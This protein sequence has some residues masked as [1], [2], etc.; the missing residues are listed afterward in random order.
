MS[1]LRGRLT[2][3]LLVGTGLLLAA[4]GLALDLVIHARLLRD[5]D[6]HLAV[7]ARSLIALV[8]QQEGRIWLELADTMMPEFEAAKEADYFQI[9]SGDGSPV[10]R[11][12]SLGARHLP[13]AG[14]P[15][16]RPLIRDL[17]LPDGR[18]GRLVE[19]RFHPRYEDDE[20]YA[21]RGGLPAPPTGGLEATIVVASSREELDAFLSSLHRILALA[22]LALLAGTTLLV[23][24]SL[25]VGL[26][27][28]DD[29]GHRLTAM[30]ADSL[31]QGLDAKGAPAELLPLLLRFEELL[32]RLQAS[33]QRE[34]EFSAHLAHELRTPL[35]ELRA[36]A[37]VAL[38]WPD[39]SAQPALFEEVRD[40]GLQME[41]IVLNLLALAR[42]DGGLQTVSTSEVPLRD[43][44]ESCWRPLAR[45]AAERG[46]DVRMDIP[47]GLLVRTDREKL[48]L[49]VSNL[50]S[51]AVAYGVP[52]GRITCAATTAHGRLGL[53]VANPT[54]SLEPDDLPRIFDRFWRKDPA[55]SGGQHAGLGLTL[56]S[57]LCGLLGLAVEAR[58]VQGVFEIGCWGLEEAPDEASSGLRLSPHQPPG[59]LNVAP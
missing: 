42:C 16:G 38:C 44:V 51:N 49:I 7:K 2:V 55:R 23:K 20:E 3:W 11:S 59:R 12:R 28:L 29:L 33:L 46:I 58:L 35:A 36:L 57:A 13:R 15:V 43:A 25:Q 26:A 24:L 53:R 47:V 1:S 10:E 54:A 18:S 21:R 34:R 37:D 40:I 17:T 48:V 4:G 41:R 5:L 56:V 8:E 6:E 14:I 27:P 45:A 30:H 39:D 22:L 32:A 9:W 31:R 19:I 52:G 50:L